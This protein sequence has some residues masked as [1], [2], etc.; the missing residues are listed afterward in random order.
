MGRIIGMDVG[1]TD[2]HIVAIDG[3]GQP[4]IIPTQ[5]RIAFKD[6]KYLGT[7]YKPNITQDLSLILQG[8]KQN[9]EKYL[10][11]KVDAAVISVPSYF[12]TVQRQAVK[13]AAKIAGIDTKR[14]I[15]EATAAGL[16]YY[17][18]NFEN[19]KEEK[20]LLVCT[21]DGEIF[22]FSALYVGEGVSEVLAVNGDAVHDSHQI[23]EL[24]A[25]ALTKKYWRIHVLHQVILKK[26]F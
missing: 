25:E 13:D 10:G 14:L 1:V 21:F 23:N 26:S 18:E 12:Y 17:F 7:E 8:L 4:F 5:E 11:E 24:T 2:S 22:D 15:S 20:I 6:K 9:A 3:G 19:L 16:S